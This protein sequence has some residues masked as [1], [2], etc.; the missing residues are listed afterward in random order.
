MDVSREQLCTRGVNPTI[1]RASSKMFP[2]LGSSYSKIVPSEEEVLSNWYIPCPS[3]DRLTC[4][5]RVWTPLTARESYRCG[6]VFQES[7]SGDIYKCLACLTSSI[8]K[9]RTFLN[10]LAIFTLCLLEYCKV[11]RTSPKISTLFPAFV[12]ATRDPG[13]INSFHPRQFFIGVFVDVIKSRLNC[14]NT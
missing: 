11:C 14:K 6:L 5:E 2:T 4:N 8:L 1:L 3:R 9:E 7:R 12:S 13:L 10:L